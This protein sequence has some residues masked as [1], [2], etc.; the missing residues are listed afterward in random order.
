MGDRLSTAGGHWQPMD[1]Q[2]PGQTF[3]TTAD[4][5]Q[6]DNTYIDVAL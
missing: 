3:P 6:M 4:Q 2:I 1:A 5:Q